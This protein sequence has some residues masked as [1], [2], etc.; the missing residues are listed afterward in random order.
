MKEEKR[1]K[2]QDEL[3]KKQSQQLPEFLPLIEP[4][5]K[6]S[7]KNFEQQNQ[8]SQQQGNKVTVELSDLNW[9]E[10]ETVL[11]LLFSKMNT[12]EAAQHWREAAPTRGSSKG[13]YT[14]NN[15]G[16]YSESNSDG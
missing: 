12:G 8:I 4:G 2:L 3:D 10:R 16:Q 15:E 7:K 14:E 1:R 6:F 13:A 11:R 9:V 5:S